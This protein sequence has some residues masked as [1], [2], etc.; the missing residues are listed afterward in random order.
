MRL[1]EAVAGVLDAIADV[2]RTEMNG[3]T[4][5]GVRSVI[6]GARARPMP[7]MPAIWIVPQPASYEQETFG[8]AEGWTMPV[9]VAA[10]VKSE[11]PEAGARDCLRLAALARSAVL[12]ARRLHLEGVVI[13]TVSDRFDAAAR[14]SERNRNLF[15]ADAVVRVHFI[16]DELAPPPAPRVGGAFDGGFS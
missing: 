14:S 12:S 9:S 4:L 3:G 7:P 16:V 1:D 11:D 10:L 13:D 15:W 2:I 6:G 8:D 5:D